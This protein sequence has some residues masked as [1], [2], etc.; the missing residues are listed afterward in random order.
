[1]EYLLSNLVDHIAR[2][3]PE[4]S[5]VDEDY[6]QLEN[7]D[8]DDANM[9]P[10]TYPAVLIEP[11]RIDWSHLSGGSQKG[12]ARLRIRLIIDCYD[13]T[14][15]GSGTRDYIRIREAMRMRL[16]S[17]V[18]GYRPL[19][20]G[21]M[22]RQESTFFTFSHGIKV[23]ESVYTCTVTEILTR[24]GTVRRHAPIRLSLK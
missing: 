4:L 9:Y 8:K 10:L 15:S 17:L 18:E 11:S 19:G 23:Y 13:D 20:D 21:A 2:E 12:E 24:Q 22:M 6:G 5:L 7:L 14:H 3:M 16:H 1:M